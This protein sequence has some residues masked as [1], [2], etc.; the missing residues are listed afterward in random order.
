LFNSLRRN[1][2]HPEA[3]LDAVVIAA[4]D[5]NIGFRSGSYKVV[6]V[7]TDAESH[8]YPQGRDLCGIQTENNLDGVMDGFPPG[9]GE[10]Y[11]SV[12]GVRQ[13]LVRSDVNPIFAA[14]D[15]VSPF[16]RNVTG[17]I[18][19]GS[20]VTISSDSANIVQA[21]VNGTRDVLQRAVLAED[22]DSDNVIV[23][24]NPL[25]F[26][27]VKGGSSVTFN[28]TLLV[29]PMSEV[30]GS[31]TY[32]TARYVGFGNI[33]TFNVH[34]AIQC[35]GCDPNNPASK[36]DIC[37]VCAGNGSSCVGCD[38]VPYSGVVEDACGTCG[39]DN[40]TCRG[41]DGTINGPQF[42]Q[43]GVC[44]GDGTTCLGCD[45]VAFSGQVENECGEC[46]GNPDCKAIQ[47]AIAGLTALAVVGVIVAVGALAFMLA[48]GKTL[49][50]ADTI[51]FQKLTQIK[52][53]PLY[54]ESN[55]VKSN[56]LYRGYD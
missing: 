40:S 52:E 36:V 15:I 11:P 10:D 24:I 13:A 48:A 8:Y 16:W 49:M 50:A 29:D 41:C 26:T 18:G 19:F 45:G 43:C 4:Q 55:T 56:P 31:S 12:L 32:A 42:D 1:F 51:L 30:V 6:M 44:G 33:V 53:N 46:G 27:G 25:S 3:S 34:T 38:G 47:G 20:Y 14:I 21:I 54:K 2:E 17:T 9:S 28:V 5:P 37:G 7:V 23:Q 39:G 22:T 35:K